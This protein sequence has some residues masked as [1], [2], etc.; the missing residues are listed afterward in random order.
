MTSNPPLSQ[1]TPA[2]S[3]VGESA[4]LLYMQLDKEL[5][6][7][8]SQNNKLLKSIKA[9]GSIVLGDDGRGKYVIT[10]LNRKGDVATKVGGTHNETEALLIG[11]TIALTLSGGRI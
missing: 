7:H 11:M 9:D 1:V 8:T 3:K 5:L 6:E 10:V 2:I 4:K